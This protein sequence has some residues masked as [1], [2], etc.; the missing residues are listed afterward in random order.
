MFDWFNLW[1]SLIQLLAKY[2][3]DVEHVIFAVLLIVDRN[4][5]YNFEL[6]FLSS[7][8]M[9]LSLI[10]EFE[11][12]YFLFVVFFSSLIAKFDYDVWTCYICD[13]IKFG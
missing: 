2:N 3:Y 7:I 10:N 5:G 4:Q 13:F 9:F 8:M 12:C 11:A 1:F 6:V